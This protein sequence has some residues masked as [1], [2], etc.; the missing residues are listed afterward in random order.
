LPENHAFIRIINTTNKAD[1][2]AGN[3]TLPFI[4]GSLTDKSTGNVAKN[5]F[6]A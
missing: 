3:Q 2:G 4:E 5:L 1:C 6:K